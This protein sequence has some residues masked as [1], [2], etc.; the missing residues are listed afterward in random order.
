[1]TLFL[2][3]TMPLETYNIETQKWYM[4]IQGWKSVQIINMMEKKVV[5][6]NM[7]T[8]FESRIDSLL[9]YVS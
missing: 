9:R 3:I 8:D 1:M 5:L 6:Q 4:N 2:N 7:K